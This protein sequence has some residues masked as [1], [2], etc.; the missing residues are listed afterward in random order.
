VVATWIWIAFCYCFAVVSWC[1]R[2]LETLQWLR[3]SDLARDATIVMEA[4]QFTSW[5]CGSFHGCSRRIFVDSMG[6]SLV[7]VPV[8]EKDG[9][10][11]C[12]RDG[13]RLK[14]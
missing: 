14:V 7:M 5:R 9:H 2:C 3:K 10:G 8:G 11:G 12:C 4:R 13:A 6:L 1:A